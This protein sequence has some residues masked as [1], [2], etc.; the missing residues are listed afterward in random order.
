VHNVQ[1]YLTTIADNDSN[2]SV[3]VVVLPSR[4][5]PEAEIQSEGS[6][7]YRMPEQTEYLLDQLRLRSLMEVAPEQL[8]RAI[9][10]LLE[11]PD[12]INQPIYNTSSVASKVFHLKRLLED[13]RIYNLD[14]KIKAFTEY[15]LNEDVIPFERSPLVGES[16]PKAVKLLAIGMGA[17]NWLRRSRTESSSVYHRSGRYDYNRRVRRS[18][19]S[20]RGKGL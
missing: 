17:F 11:N 6:Q 7:G 3:S 8:H 2:L 16:L 1:S 18:G 4:S 9:T 12:D 5:V 10:A 13:D 15:I 19:Q 14:R 20:A